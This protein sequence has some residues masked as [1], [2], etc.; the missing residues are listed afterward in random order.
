MPLL[1]LAMV[2]VLDSAEINKGI[3][4]DS[5]TYLNDGLW[6]SNVSNLNLR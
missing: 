5:I 2:C 4:V 6:R 3:G 1:P